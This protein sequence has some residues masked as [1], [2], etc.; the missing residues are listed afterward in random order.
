MDT[1]IYLFLLSLFKIVS[2]FAVLQLYDVSESSCM[3]YLRVNSLL[4]ECCS[5][6]IGIPELLGWCL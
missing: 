4:L 6:L 2:V 5:R 3:M 1:G